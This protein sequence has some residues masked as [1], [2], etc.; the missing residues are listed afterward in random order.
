MNKLP[1]IKPG[2]CDIP[3]DPLNIGQECTF[4]QGWWYQKT[5]AQNF[6]PIPSN[7]VWSIRDKGRYNWMTTPHIE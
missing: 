3:Y 5:M 7:L 2:S 6:G 1:V 4:P